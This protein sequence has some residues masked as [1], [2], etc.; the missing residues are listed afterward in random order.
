MRAPGFIPERHR[1][2]VHLVAKTGIARSGQVAREGTVEQWEH[3][4]GTMDATVRLRPFRLRLRPQ[5]L[6]RAEV[7]RLMAEFERAV[8]LN[9]A[10]IRS[11]DRSLHRR[12]AATVV[13]VKERLVRE[14]A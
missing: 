7:Q 13:E 5:D 9:E 6:S 1:K 3:W 14:L 4:D 8:R 2:G 12:T 10:A 11:G